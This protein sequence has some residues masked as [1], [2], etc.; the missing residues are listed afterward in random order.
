MW[1]SCGDGCE[2]ASTL[3]KYD[4]R[5]GYL[6]APSWVRVRQVRRGSVSVPRRHSLHEIGML[7]RSAQIVLTKSLLPEMGARICFFGQAGRRSLLLTKVGDVKSN[8]GPTIRTNK[9]QSFGFVTSV[10]NNTSIRCNNTDKTAT[11]QT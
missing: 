5:E 10:T 7:Q 1:C 4:L 2:L 9:L 3:C 8:P 11:I 6:F